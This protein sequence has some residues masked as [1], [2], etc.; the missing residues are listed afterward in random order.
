MMRTIICLLSCLLLAAGASAETA[1]LKLRVVYDGE[2]PKPKPIRAPRIAG[3][4]PN[5]QLLVDPAT[6]GISNV[7]VYLY[8][9]RGGS[10]VQRTEKP[11]QIRQLVMQ[12]FRF[13]P[14]VVILRAGDTLE[15]VQRGRVT[16]APNLNLFRNLPVGVTIPPGKPQRFE[17]PHAEPGL[18]PV[19]CNIHP[20]MKAHLLVIDHPFAAKSD[21]QG[22]IVIEDLPAGERLVFRVW[23]EAA[24][25]KIGVVHL[26]GEALDLGRR[27]LFERELNPGVNDLGT[28]LIPAEAFKTE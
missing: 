20:W 13:S 16:Y 8:T 18:V 9:G 17:L 28:L 14:R 19:D 27:N 22:E 25:G 6:N 26:D 7:L 12:N 3:N 11:G 2:P 5:E 24:D 1:T 21:Q 10:N 15:L 4:I 23:I